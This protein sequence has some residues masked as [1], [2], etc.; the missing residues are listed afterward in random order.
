MSDPELRGA[1]ARGAAPPRRVRH[2]I[3]V[4]GGRGGVGKSILAGNLGVY[5][6]QLGRKVVL[7]DA[8]PAGAELHTML[9]VD[10]P[11][12]PRAQEEPEEDELTLV[13]TPIPGLLL[14]PQRYRV[15]ST[16]PL[17]PGRKARWA[18][19]LRQ[20]DADYVLLDLGAGTAPSTLD[21]FLFA[22]V[23]LC[24]TAPEPPSVE[25]TYRFC[26]AAFERKIRRALVKDR[27]K[28]RLVERAQAELEPLPSP[29]DLVRTIARYD[30]AVG[31]LAA[32][33]LAEL[34]PR[35]VL[36]AARLRSDTDL[37]P[38]MCDL[39]RR[40]LGVA[41][42][43]VGHIEHDDSVWLSVV[44]R[45]PL[46]IDSP[47]SK[48]ARNLERIA[49]RV[50]ALATARE[51]QRSDEPIALVPGELNLYDVLWTQ[52]SASDEE[53]R[54]AYK[55]QRE[56]YQP[57]SLP[58]TSLLGDDKL[59][60]EL[61]RIEEAHDTLLDP[62]RRRAYDISTFP[63]QTQPPP[64]RQVAIDSALA[65]ERA[66]LRQELSREINAESE[67]T[68]SL[69]RK[70]RESLGIEIEEIANHTKI[71]NAHLRAIE[72]EDF[73]SLPALVY[74]RGFVQQLARYLKLDPA[75]VTRTYLRR[76]RQWRAASGG[77]MAP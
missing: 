23:G 67:F 45:R 65:A 27:F 72:A 30:S 49:R 55:R 12:P 20:L 16:L 59:H 6:A 50:L 39:A 32:T 15:G 69:L 77:E 52:P 29:Q 38:A 60:V 76:M 13:A 1:D 47:T 5:L 34:R 57:G 18:R 36:N 2:V 28:M 75:Q 31:E 4:G 43:Y 64:E 62:M 14:S 10:L 40:Y 37:G 21:L 46:L 51:Q 66:L 63:E 25:A 8:D 19:G 53:L 54:R 41:L 26:R 7:V 22:D 3:A 44:R 17:R 33:E 35:L 61:A 58:L 56:I 71:A 70:V 24:V 74:T 42:D 11:A 68:G 48:S 9:G 73:G